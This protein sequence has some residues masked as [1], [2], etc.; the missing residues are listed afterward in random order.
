[1]PITKSEKKY[2]VIDLFAGC[3]GLSEG[4]KQAGFEIVAQIEMDKWACESL[5]TRCLYWQLKE[6][7]KI[8]FYQKYLRNDITWKD[9]MN[10]FPEIKKIIS[11]CVIQ[12][13]FGNDAI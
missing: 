1:M 12:A 6:R 11:Y 13:T 5:K 7:N 2:C 10:R 3:G 8:Y 4:F 9:I